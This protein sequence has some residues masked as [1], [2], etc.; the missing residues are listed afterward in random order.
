MILEELDSHLV[1]FSPYESLTKLLRSDAQL[2]DLGQ[3]AW[4]AL[5][6]AYR[7][8]LPLM[9]PPHLIAI[10]CVYLASVICSRDISTW[11]ATLN[12]DDNLVSEC[13]LHLS[14]VTSCWC[15]EK[16]PGLSV[17]ASF[18][19]SYVR[20]WQTELIPAKYIGCSSSSLFKHC[21]CLATLLNTVNLLNT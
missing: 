9:Y 5:N 17:A 10:G 15:L 18:H 3:N 19:K 21:Y 20:L 2:A 11:L 6:D 7:T 1:V 12:A 16:D 13:A 4:A 8:D 14:L